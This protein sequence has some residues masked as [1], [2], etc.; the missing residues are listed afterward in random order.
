VLRK[1]VTTRILHAHDFRHRR[2]HLGRESG[3]ERCERFACR[4]LAQQPVAKIPD[5]QMRYRRK[6]SG[7]VLVNDQARYFVCFIGNQELRK[8]GRERQFR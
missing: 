5:G 7:I 2:G 1:R 6:G 4:V 3:R 8:K